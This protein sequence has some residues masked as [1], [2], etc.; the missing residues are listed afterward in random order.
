MIP[1]HLKSLQALEL[2]MRTGSLTAAGKLLGITT[3]AVGQRIKTLEEHLGFD[4]LVRARSGIRLTPELS[5][6]LPHIAAAF[7]ELETAAHLLDFQRG[8]EIHVLANT[9]WAELWLKTRLSEFKAANPNILFC[10]NGVG[11]VPL[12]LGQ[13]DCEVWFG[14][15]R[16]GYGEEMLFRD[17]LLPVASPENTKRVSSLD[18]A[19]RLEGFPLLHLNCYRTDPV[20]IG[21]PEWI[22]A[23]GYRKTAAERG[24][25]YAH[26]LQAL[27]AVFSDAGMLICGLALVQS[28]LES[29]IISL[30]FAISQGAWTEHAYYAAFRESAV[31]RTQ[32]AAFRSW[33]L[34]KSSET[35]GHL[36]KLL[37]RD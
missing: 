34:E 1:T 11:D 36:E 20:A 33:L 3:A 6:A 4:L 24:I 17:Y 37:A 29:G 31:R 5:A 35:T 14:E 27:E 12:R 26:V 23:H 22:S 9:D 10:V 28:Q 25:R 13:A 32:V 8:L 18:A 7:R 16:G 19:E 30:P 2:A 21:W 15:P